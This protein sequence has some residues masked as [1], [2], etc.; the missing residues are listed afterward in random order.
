MVFIEVKG[1]KIAIMTVYRL[2][3]SN[4]NRICTSK[5]WLDKAAKQVKTAKKHRNKMMKDL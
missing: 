5:V 3:D 4:T 1:K 2:L